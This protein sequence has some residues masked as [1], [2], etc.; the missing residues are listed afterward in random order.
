[1]CATVHNHE[2]LLSK[3]Y[4][5]WRKNLPHLLDQYRSSTFE[6]PLMLYKTK[7]M[8]A[9]SSSDTRRYV[10]N[11]FDQLA[12]NVKKFIRKLNT[13]QSLKD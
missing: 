2:M 12:K 4:C 9:V 13:D 5:Y 8:F 6:L 1:M 10:I 3:T 11:D 7:W